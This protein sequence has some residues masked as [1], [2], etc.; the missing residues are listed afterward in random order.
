MKTEI[1]D[2]NVGHRCAAL[3]DPGWVYYGPAAIIP[4]PW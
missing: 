1:V 4:G 3:F 2:N